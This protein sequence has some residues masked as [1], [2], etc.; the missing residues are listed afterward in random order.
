MSRCSRA[1]RTLGSYLNI[2]HFRK[3]GGLIAVSNSAGRVL[4]RTY[5][6]DDRVIVAVDQNGVAVTNAYDNLGRT[7]TRTYPDTGEERFGYS[8][9][10]LMAY[11][12][13]LTS[14][15]TYYAYDAPRRK[16]AETNAL[17]QITQY[18]YS[19]AS[20]LISLT[21]AKTNTTQWGY[22]LYGRVTNKVDATGTNI[23]KYQ[24]DAD[25][26]LTNRWSL[27][28]S[29]TVYSYDAVG[30]LTNVTYS[31][32]VTNHINQPL[33]FAYDAI[34]EM[35][36][37]LDGLGTTAFTYTPGG[38]LASESGPWAGDTVAYA[39]TNRLRTKL[40]LQQPNADDW[41]E[42]YAYDTANR[43]KSVTS[44]AGTFGYSYN[45]GLVG[46]G[47]LGT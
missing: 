29:N 39:Y 32:N 6:I 40:D 3:Q 28:K 9:F 12:N 23:L 44:P 18:G 14:N 27:A 22:D 17:T 19:H 8:S 36:S 7:L 42:S 15:V 43:M 37:M 34:N 2:K 20:D 4:S 33:S 21:D 16:M 30:N 38:Q 47:A 45:P 13:Q 31:T 26:R 5:D 35:T 10:G 25:S 11:T 46:T 41:V 24:Y 1:V